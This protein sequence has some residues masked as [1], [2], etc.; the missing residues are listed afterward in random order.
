MKVDNIDKLRLTI[1][2]KNPLV[3]TKKYTVEA[4]C[5]WSEAIDISKKGT[6]LYSTFEESSVIHQR[7]LRSTEE[8][9][10]IPSG[11]RWM[12]APLLV[13]K[14]HVQLD[15]HSQ[16]LSTLKYDQF[17]LEIS[18]SLNNIHKILCKNVMCEYSI[19]IES[20][21]QTTSDETLFL[22]IHELNA[23][24]TVLPSSIPEP[25]TQSLMFFGQIHSATGF[26]RNVFIK[27]ELQVPSEWNTTNSILKS[28]T[29]VSVGDN[30]HHF[31]H[32]IQ[33]TL[34]TNGIFY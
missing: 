34:L 13:M 4:T 23:S 11:L 29:H 17:N 2:F 27:Y 22:A 1:R 16:V 32:A 6:R 5:L 24:K 10:G 14:L 8:H 30:D 28:C 12:N 33:F 25:Y 19:E 18:P 7:D 15:D 20:N 31:G 21:P 3:N 9:L 26:T